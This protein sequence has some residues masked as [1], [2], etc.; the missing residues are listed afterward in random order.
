MMNGRITTF[1]EDK[2]FGFI[3][4]EN[5]DNRY[6]HV[7]KVANPE[8]IKKGAEVT[9]EPTTNT[10]GLSAFAVKV[11]I[12]SKYIFI[13]NERIKLTSIKSFNTFTKEVPAQ[14]EIDKANTI[15]S[16]NLL[17]NKIRPQEEDI[18]EKTVPLKMLSITTFQ[19]T[20]YTFSEHEVDID[21]TIAKLK[22][23]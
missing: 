20:T 14:A 7:I 19:N 21:S 1:F 17:M 11:A 8:M 12:E 2:G 6:F 3:T 13:A 5:G 4:D 10:K 18:S 22:S 16:V 23:I 9:F 15:L